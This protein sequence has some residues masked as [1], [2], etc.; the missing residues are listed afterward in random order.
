MKRGFWIGYRLFKMSTTRSGFW[1][2][3]H[4]LRLLGLLFGRQRI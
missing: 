3:Y 1:F 2:L 4:L